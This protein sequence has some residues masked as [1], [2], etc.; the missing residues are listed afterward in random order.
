[1]K[2]QIALALLIPTA[3]FAA[4]PVDGTWKTDPTTMTI[5][6]K[7]NV[8]KLKDGMY[9]CSSCT[10]SYTVKADGT[11]QPVKGRSYADMIAVTVTD[12]SNV[13]ISG[14]LGGKP[15]FT[16]TLSVSPDGKTLTSSF[17]QVTAGT[18]PVTGTAVGTRKG[19]A[20]PGEG[21]TG[22]WE[23]NTPATGMTDTQL[24]VMYATSADGISMK[25]NGQAYDAKFD[26]KQVPIS[27]D[28]GNTMASLKKVSD[29]EFIE[30]DYRMG[31]KVEVTDVKISADGK[32]A[33][34]LDKDLRNDTV[35]KY[36]MNKQ[37]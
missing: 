23:F 10:P 2:I 24:T 33:M 15:S 5:K 27:N 36:T 11:D 29:H 20:K 4:S 37:S 35:T 12:A 16:N 8:Y 30:T 32:T 7:P 28:P 19:S 17:K 25:W 9:T 34:V 26:G 18:E 1:M 3:A 14:K 6:S 13:T 31:K 21:I 22:K